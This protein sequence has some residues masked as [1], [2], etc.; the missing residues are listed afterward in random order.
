M[1]FCP[2]CGVSI[3][4][5]GHAWC[6]E[7][8]ASLAPSGAAQPSPPPAPPAAQPI[9]APE[10]IPAPRPI[11]APQY[12]SAAQAPPP[13]Q[14]PPPSSPEVGPLPG[15]KSLSNPL[16][17]G[18]G[19]LIAG[20]L[21]GVVALGVAGF[22]VLRLINPSGGASS[23]EDAVTE[24]VAGLSDQDP[25]AA[26][27]M[28]N[29][30]EVEGL[31]ELF[32]TATERLEEAGVSGGGEILD[33]AE[34]TVEG[35]EVDVEPMGEHAARVYI[36]GGVLA[37][38]LDPETL[39]ERFATV[40]DL[41]KSRSWDIELTS[42]LGMDGLE[43][44]EEQPFLTVVEVDGRW[45][46]SLL[47]TVGEYV[48]DG[49][50]NQGG[51]FDYLAG[52]DE[53]KPDVAEDPEDALSNTL[54]ALS[55]NDVEGLIDSLPQNQWGVLRAYVDLAG[56]IMDD[57]AV[58]Y[59]VD[60]GT[61]R[62]SVEEDGDTAKLTL[63][64]VEMYT[65]GSAGDD[66]GEGSLLINGD[67][68]VVAGA[69]ETCISRRFTE[70]TGIDSYYVMLRREGEGWQVDPLGT[71]VS[72]AKQVLA[73]IPEDVALRAYDLEGLIEPTAALAS[74]ETTSVKL[75]ESGVGVATLS[76]TKGQWIKV[77]LEGE[78]EANVF[79]PGR[80]R[81]GDWVGS[82]G[83]AVLASEDGDY[84][85]VLEDWENGYEAG[86]VDVTA[87]LVEPVKAG[88]DD[89][90]SAGDVHVLDLTGEY[91]V[92]EGMSLYE[93]DGDQVYDYYS[94]DGEYVAF[95]FE[96]GVKLEEVS[97][98]FED[99]STSFSG[100]L[101][102][103]ASVDFTVTAGQSVYITAYAEFDLTLEI[104]EED[105]YE[106]SE[107]GGETEYLYFTPSRSGTYTLSV[108][109]IGGYGGAFYLDL[110]EE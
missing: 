47:G 99:G 97:L 72:Y 68:L 31:D 60:V 104:E 20:G 84:R 100:E 32:N 71:L 61:L 82:E 102:D 103:D 85:V 4:D 12:F 10:P 19:R 66:Y 24:L 106:D 80:T 86:S 55:D 70:L 35:L 110:S 34:I 48:A 49:T 21:L 87:T 52:D 83:G 63:D 78:V 8:G 28:I 11:P 98:G 43:L 77:D 90:M 46:V 38:S 22:V 2:N 59:T 89:L 30:G 23:P 18:K 108:D 81:Y 62:T 37:V 26:L 109:D 14:V 33:A 75:G 69:D 92:P 29:P 1:K 53:I 44:T 76:A 64:D 16:G 107:L 13:W 91:V 73:T 5:L 101:Y 7:C 58:S 9:S 79:R 41:E 25:V 93:A 88:P 95:A 65:S 105:V 42:I 56:D 3:P 96:D 17:S 45:Y 6:A 36:D 39:P 40:A 50:N 54:D 15:A 57:N 74:G 51:D 94:F 27:R 67:C